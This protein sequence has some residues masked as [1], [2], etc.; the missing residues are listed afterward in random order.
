MVEISTETASIPET[1][2]NLVPIKGNITISRKVYRNFNEAAT[3]WKS[4][5]AVKTRTNYNIYVKADDLKTFILNHDRMTKFQALRDASASA[6]DLS[7]KCYAMLTAL[8]TDILHTDNETLIINQYTVHVSKP[9]ETFQ[10][11]LLATRMPEHDEEATDVDNDQNN[12]QT[13]QQVGLKN[14]E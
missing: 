1:I 5:N 8:L 12:K 9:W 11:D 6:T 7:L 3:Y 13:S 14:Y 2:D 10:I 4:R